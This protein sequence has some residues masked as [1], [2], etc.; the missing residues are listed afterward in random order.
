MVTGQKPF[1]N[2]MSQ[3]SLIRSGTMRNARKVEFP[4]KIKLSTSTKEF[5]SR[6]LSYFP[7][8]RPDILEIFSDPYFQSSRKSSS[9]RS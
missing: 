4:E 7:A 5:I 3:E 6:C 2:G 1:G 9:S 8:D